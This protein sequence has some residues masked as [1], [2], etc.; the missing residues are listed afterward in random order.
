NRIS[1]LASA[2][3]QLNGSFTPT[4]K[5]VFTRNQY[6]YSVGGPVIKDKLLFFQSTE[7]LRVRSSD[8]AI[9]L[10]PTPEFI[11]Q[12]PANV[13]A[14]FAPFSLST[15]INGQIFTRQQIVPNAGGPF[16]SLPSNL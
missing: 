3:S 11:A 7:W 4:Q 13:Q 1:R 8:T 10:V 15:P 6:G 14:F 12:T 5:G 16:A 2:S 9:A